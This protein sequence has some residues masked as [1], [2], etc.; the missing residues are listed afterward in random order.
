MFISWSGDKSKE[1]ANLFYEWLPSVIQV[2]KPYFSPDEIEKGARWSN[3]ISKE[4]NESTIGLICLTRDNLE[5]PWIMFEA[6][7]LSKSLE[8]SRV[9]PIL[10]GLEP[11]DIKGPLIQFQG[12]QFSNEEVKKIITTIN[13]SLESNK[14]KQSVLDGVFDKWWPDL[15]QKVKKILAKDTLPSSNQ[16][17]PDRDI[18]EEILTLTRR[19][20]AGGSPSRIHPQALA[21]LTKSY[22]DLLEALSIQDSSPDIVRSIL[23][24]QGPMAHILDRERTPSKTKRKIERLL[25][26]I[27]VRTPDEEED[28]DNDDIFA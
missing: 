17:R 28:E 26:V 23:N 15:E 12:A 3:E 16:L 5:S 14:L 9:C 27:I 20:T 21:D 13:N 22:I 10:F 25:D 19:T 24:L 18:L 1:L 2:V 4:L 8:K 6:G 7:A 11:S